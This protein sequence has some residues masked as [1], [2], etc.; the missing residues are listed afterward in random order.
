MK[1]VETISIVAVAVAL[2]IGSAA[3]SSKPGGVAGTGGTS[4]VGGSLACAAGAVP[5]GAAGALAC[6]SNPAD[7]AFAFQ[8]PCKPI[9]DRI[10]DLL[11]QLTTAEKQSLLGEDQPAIPRLG[12]PG[13]TT[14]TE[15]IH[16]IGWSDNGNGSVSNLLGTQFPQ[17]FGLAEAW[18]PQVHEDRRRDHRLRGARAQREGNLRHRARS[19]HRGARAAHRCRARPALGAHRGILRRG[20]LPDRRAGQGLSRRFARRRSEVPARGLDAQAL[21][22]QQQ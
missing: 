15:G 3:C 1:R 16:G 5:T 2:W 8:D 11:A 19:R 6:T 10:S 21:A 14:F 20:S 12:L 22:G 7:Y 4:G 9:E 17:A 13:F 18:D